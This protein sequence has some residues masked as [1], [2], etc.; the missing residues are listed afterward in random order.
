MGVYRRGKIWYIR[1]KAPNGRIIRE[2]TAQESKTLAQSILQKRKTTVAEGK[3]LDKQERPEITFPE[4]CEWYWEH[5]GQRRSWNGI[6][7]MLKRFKAFFG[8][9]PL[10]AITPERIS[11]YRAERIARDGIKP[12]TANRDLQ[13]LK[14]MF[15]LIINYKRWRRVLENPVVYVKLAREDQ[16]RVRFLEPEDIQRLLAACDDHLRPI[17]L[18]ALHTGMR[19]GEILGLKWAD[20]DL[21]RRTLFVRQTKTGEG[22]HLPISEELLGMLSARP[23]RFKGGYVFASFLPRRN[24]GTSGEKN[25][26]FVDIKNSFRT[27]LER[28][29]IHDFRFHDL[30]HTFASQLVMNGADLTVVR[31]LLGHKS[32]TMTLRY[33]TWHPAR[34]TRRLPSLTGLLRSKIHPQVTH[35]VTQSVF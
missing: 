24:N 34:N 35:L 16:L 5:H 28:A 33:A 19:R 11:E 31:D 21:R 26:P 9:V 1:Y 10:V 25:D 15:N 27:A 18:T 23:S 7:G 22:R 14:S 8:P 13:L 2:S 3:F 20:V 6:W 32:M 30:R 12:I 29:G 4:L 17:V